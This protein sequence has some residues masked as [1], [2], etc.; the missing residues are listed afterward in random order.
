[1]NSVTQEEEEAEGED[2]SKEKRGRVGGGIR[3]YKS[4]EMLQRVLERER[5]GERGEWER[6]VRGERGDIGEI[7][8][9]LFCSLVITTLQRRLFL[10]MS[11]SLRRHVKIGGSEER[12][13]RQS[14]REGEGEREKDAN[15]GESD[16]L[17][18][19]S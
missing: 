19:L 4:V 7:P 3:A 5:W 2:G 18:S 1:M 10:E 12:P 9:D 13:L 6:E 11:R 15:K 16:V 14:E 8:K 17:L